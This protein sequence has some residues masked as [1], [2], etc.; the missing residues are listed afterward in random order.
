MDASKPIGQLEV[1]FAFSRHLGP[2]HIHGAVTLQFDE[3]KSYSFTS[4]VRWPEGDNYDEPVRLAIEETLR[5]MQGHINS[6]S[7]LLKGIEWNETSSCQPAFV[8]AA[9]AAT[10]AAFDV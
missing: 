1:S 7:V 2:R 6:P 5:E 4:N 3:L 9:K 8:L 10:R